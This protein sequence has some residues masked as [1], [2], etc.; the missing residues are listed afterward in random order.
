MDY[1]QRKLDS[2]NRLTIPSQLRDEF[3]Q[4]VVITPGFKNYLHLYPQDVWNSEMET[5]LKG[6]IL[7]ESIADINV[8]FRAGKTIAA[9]DKKQG[10]IT[11]EAHQVA[12]LGGAR[13]VTAVRAG[14]YF[15]LSP[16]KS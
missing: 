12:L 5:A 1:W 4:N 8:R 13:E 11:L 7:D 9:L 15:R 6:D 16:K 3:G 10:R 2:K 14:K